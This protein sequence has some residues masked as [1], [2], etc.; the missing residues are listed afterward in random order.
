MELLAQDFLLL[1]LSELLLFGLLLTVDVR[2]CVWSIVL[3]IDEE[4]D[5]LDLVTHYE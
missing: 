2:G 5:H 1:L 3:L 4:P